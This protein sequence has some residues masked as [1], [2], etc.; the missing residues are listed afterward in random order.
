MGEMM[1]SPAPGFHQQMRRAGVLW[2]CPVSLLE[3]QAPLP[4]HWLQAQVCPEHP[5]TA[6]GVKEIPLSHP[7]LG[8]CLLLAETL[9]AGFISPGSGGRPGRVSGLLSAH[10]HSAG[11]LGTCQTKRPEQA[12]P[13][14][15][16]PQSP[17]CSLAASSPSLPGLE[18]SFSV[19]SPDPVSHGSRRASY[20]PVR[21]SPQPETDA[22]G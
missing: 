6:H 1:V 2:G 13:A 21:L 11:A 9:K 16:A 3:L 14:W 10:T 12:R 17:T 15:R 19:Q 20:N 4:P 7:S 5:R 8:G 22:Q 18:H